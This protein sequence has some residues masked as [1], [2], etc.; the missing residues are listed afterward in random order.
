MNLTRRPLVAGLCLGLLAYKP[1]FGILF[2]LV[3]AFDGRWR[4]IVTATA[5]A[6]VL[7][8]A[9]VAAFGLD[10]W[11]AFIEWMPVTSTAVFEDGRAGLNKLQSLFGVLRWLGGSMTTA[12]I[13][14][15][16]LIAGATIAL[17]LLNRQRVPG[18][19]KAAALGVAALLATPYLYI[20][21]FPV[22]A[23]PLAFLIKLGLRDGFLP[24][25]LAAIALA[26]ALVLIFPF[27]ALPT[28]FVAAVIVAA[29]VARRAT[30]EI[31]V[32]PALRTTTAA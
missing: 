14:Q 8:V 31:A 28:G 17:I 15:A 7:I 3:L 18:E 29:L 9:S 4:V 5:T 30:A 21:D 26:C 10:S 25:E 16:L 6:A 11:R 1:Q 23:I 12:F 20:Y 22:L 13:A 19:V 24:Y 27:V 2:P 32:A